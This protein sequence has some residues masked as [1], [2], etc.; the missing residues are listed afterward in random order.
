MPQITWI[1]FLMPPAEKS[2]NKTARSWACAQV[3]QHIVNVIDSQSFSMG[4]NPA[5]W[6]A[7]RYFREANVSSSTI[8]AFA[9]FNGTTIG[10]TSR[11][12]SVL[13]KKGLVNKTV[14]TRAGFGAI[15]AV[16]VRVTERGIEVLKSDPLFLL[17]SSIAKLPRATRD[18]LFE[19]LGLIS[20]DLYSQVG[21]KKS[22]K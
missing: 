13:E 17:S 21:T 20:E 5:Q 18:A 2:N 9:E 22:K 14:D 15:K 19:A 3:V 10:T 7:L 1:L 11:T 12:V 16:T 6:A 8:K 4:L